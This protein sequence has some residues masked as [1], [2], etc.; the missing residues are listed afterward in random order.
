MKN[1]TV[2]FFLSMVLSVITVNATEQIQA[3]SLPAAAQLNME[4]RKSESHCDVQH[5]KVFF[6]VDEYGQVKVSKIDT[7]NLKLKNYILNKLAKLNF[8]GM[9]VEGEYNV[10]LSFDLGDKCT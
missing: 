3:R 5:V 10:T 6:R 7:Q 9:N 1:L 4:L 2:A 8:K